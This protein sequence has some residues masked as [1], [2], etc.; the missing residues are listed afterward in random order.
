MSTTTRLNREPPA[1]SVSEYDRFAEIYNRWMAEDFCRRALPVIDKLLLQSLPSRSHILDLCCGSGQMAGALVRRGYEVTGLDASPEML[2]L[3][4]ENVPEAEFFVADA[5]EFHSPRR[6]D[7]AISTF[8]SLA[9][10][11]TIQELAR[12][13]CNVRQA[14]RTGGAFLFDLSMEEAYSSRWRGSFSLVADDHVCVVRPEYDPQE[15]IGT[16][17]I[18]L[19][20]RGNSAWRRS[21]FDI[22]QTCHS[23]RDLRSVL[24]EAGYD[25]VKTF[26]AQR[27]LGMS[28]ESGRTFFICR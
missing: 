22:K 11:P 20:E 3:A 1:E 9:H 6:F 23:E 24:D 16:N 28:G 18:T 15:Q 4:Q 19:F 27:E 2:R 12:V 13:F 7:A 8:N 10:I 5:R 21:D 25:D 26:D 14:L 17:Y